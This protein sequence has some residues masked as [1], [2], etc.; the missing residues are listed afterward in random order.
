MNNLLGFVGIFCAITTLSACG[1]GACPSKPSGGVSAL[2]WID[3][4]NHG[5]YSCLANSDG[6]IESDT[7][8][9]SIENISTHDLT[10]I[11]VYNNWA[12]IGV[13]NGSMQSTVLYQCKVTDRVLS[14]CVSAS[15]EL[16]VLAFG[17]SCNPN[18]QT[19]ADITYVSAL[20]S[21][22][23]QNG[24][25]YLISPVNGSTTIRCAIDSATGA[26]SECTHLGTFGAIA[27]SRFRPGTFADTLYFDGV[28]NN[29]GYFILPSSVLF[30]Y[31]HVNDNFESSSQQSINLRSYGG[32]VPAGMVV[33]SNYVY[34]PNKNGIGVEICPINNLSGIESSLCINTPITNIDISGVIKG[35]TGFS[36]HIYMT[37]ADIV[38]GTNELVSCQVSKSS[39]SNC[40]VQSN[41]Y[42]NNITKFSNYSMGITIAN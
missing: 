3:N 19:C 20:T 5:V 2:Y 31:S 33:L 34:L 6:T 14:N 23:V 42:I 38:S 1:N 17:S 7:C 12:Y 32:D 13:Y 35:V 10:S 27:G 9:L 25:A 24:F 39:I 8:K 30:E 40:R 15:A 36:G 28:N 4:S 37:T 16:N 41:Q 29:F 21:M 22:A 26:L 11:T 18:Y